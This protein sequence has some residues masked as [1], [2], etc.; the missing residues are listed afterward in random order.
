MS[1]FASKADK[2]NKSNKHRTITSGINSSDIN[3]TE[4]SQSDSLKQGKSFKS[5]A[6][7]DVRRASSM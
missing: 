2:S 7:N 5:K 1:K 4:I 3:A 6:S